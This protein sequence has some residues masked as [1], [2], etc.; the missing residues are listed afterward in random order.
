M[1]FRR[2][3]PRCNT[4]PTERN[5]LHEGNR[6]HVTAIVLVAGRGSRLAGQGITAKC[7]SVIGRSTLLERQIH[8]LIGRVDR[9]VLVVGHAAQSVK[10]QASLAV[11]GQLRMDFV[12]N[13]SYSNSGT[14]ESLRIALSVV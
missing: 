13:A 1:R 2:S 5:S 4:V 9:I 7:L 11:A 14:T 6:R 10:D 3:C 12:E 8:A